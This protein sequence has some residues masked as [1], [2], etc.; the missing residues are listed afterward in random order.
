MARAE[1]AIRN[2]IGKSSK[3]AERG[4][5]VRPQ[6]SYRN[7]TNV[8]AESDV[9]VYVAAQHVFFNDYDQLDGGG[10]DPSLIERIQR[11][12]GFSVLTGYEFRTYK[13]EVEEA[14]VAHFGRGA[15]VRGDK[16]FDIHENT[17]RVDSD[18][19]AAWRYRLWGQAIGAGYASRDGIAFNPDSKP[20][21]TIFNFPEQQYANGVTKHAATRDRFKK[22]VRIL[23]NLRNE[24][25][26]AHVAAADPIPSFLIECLVWNVPNSTFTGLSFFS[27]LR[28]VLRAIYHGTTD[29]EP[30]NQRWTEENGIKFLFHPEQP[31]TRAEANTFA[32]AAWSY[33]G[34]A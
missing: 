30:D 4:V 13:D 12:A 23:K 28:E 17:Y 8:P 18:C 15:V 20:W 22:N 34:F 26:D 9:D 27:E 6:G 11:Q 10:A 25:A 33:V 32:L 3:L 16:A 7:R 24:M 31:W 21:K 29:G 1:K 5:L 2:A 14:L 19:L